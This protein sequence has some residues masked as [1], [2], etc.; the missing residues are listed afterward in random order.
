MHFS[1]FSTFFSTELF[2]QIV[3]DRWFPKLFVWCKWSNV[4]KEKRGE[5]GAVHLC[6]QSELCPLVWSGLSYATWPSVPL[7]LG[8]KEGN[9]AWHNMNRGLWTSH[10]CVWCSLWRSNLDVTV[11]HTCTHTSRERD[12]VQMGSVAETGRSQMTVCRASDVVGRKQNE[13][14]LR[15]CL[16]SHIGKSDASWSSL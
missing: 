13:L 1:K 6:G 11:T 8:T 10:L 14:H 7:A 16:T 5:E 12:D 9:L 15:A 3:L 2:L 4:G